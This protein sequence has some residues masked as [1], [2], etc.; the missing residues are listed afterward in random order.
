MDVKPPQYSPQGAL[1]NANP[2]YKITILSSQLARYSQFI[3]PL[4]VAIL[5]TLLLHEQA[6]YSQLLFF[7]L[8]LVV[9][10]LVQKKIKKQKIISNEFD[11]FTLDVAGKCTF[12][13]NDYAKENCLIT[14][15]DNVI[16]LSRQLSA[17]SRISFLGFWL[18]FEDVDKEQSNQL[19]T[20]SVAILMLPQPWFIFY[21]SLSE[22]D[23]SRLARVIN[24]LSIIQRKANNIAN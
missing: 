14:R 4:I 20:Q 15:S 13:K 12:I 16:S 6:I 2:V 1:F 24:S 17:R 7:I 21:D 22:Q 5:A 18:Y 9:F 23:F 3:L 19:I 8:T 11:T 10:R